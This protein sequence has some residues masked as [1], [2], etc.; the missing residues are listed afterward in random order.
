MLTHAYVANVTN[1]YDERFALYNKRPEARLIIGCDPGFVRLDGE[2]VVDC[3]VSIVNN[4][5]YGSWSAK[6]MR[7][8]MAEYD[9]CPVVD[10]SYDIGATLL[11]SSGSDFLPCVAGESSI[12]NIIGIH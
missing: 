9:Y 8:C 2:P 4:Q 1:P 3:V 5:I 10:L 11:D 7:C 6:P 12:G